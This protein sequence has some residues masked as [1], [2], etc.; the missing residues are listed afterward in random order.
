MPE[1][2]LDIVS[3]NTIYG[4]VC[5]QS[6]MLQLPKTTSQPSQKM[7]AEDQNIFMTN[8]NLIL[9]QMLKGANILYVYSIHM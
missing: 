9:C 5:R 1:L 7:L 4:M 6:R 8:K 2:I 3:V